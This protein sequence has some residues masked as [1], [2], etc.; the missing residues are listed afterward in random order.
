VARVGESG[1][2][3]AQWDYPKIL[4]TTLNGQWDRGFLGWLAGIPHDRPSG[5]RTP[6]FR[7]ASRETRDAAI[8]EFLHTLRQL[9]DQWLE[10]GKDRVKF[11]EQPWS[12]NV[13]WVSD[14]YQERIDRRLQKFMD[15][16]PP[17][18]EFGRDGRLAPLETVSHLWMP[19]PAAWPFPE[20]EL[21]DTLARARDHGI[22]EFQKFLGSSCPQR[23]FKCDGCGTYF[24]R[25]RTPKK[26]TAIYHGAFCER[27]KHK[28]GARRTGTS[29]NR[30]LQEMIGWAADAW[31][32]W[33]PKKPF[34]ERS[35]WVTEKVNAKL[36]RAGRDL[37]KVNWVSRHRAEIEIEVERR[38]YAK[39]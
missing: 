10:S 16:N 4:V 26:E 22:A 35:D 31:V 27:C 38:N 36:L 12:R 21:E 8:S 25:T 29:R 15:R 5:I 39:G 19:K 3:G 37:I 9:V 34:V 7:N 33:K 20:P 11:A 6:G 23:L 32:K 13:F 30:R 24:V 17:P 1:T 14:T 2:K 18:N 28:G